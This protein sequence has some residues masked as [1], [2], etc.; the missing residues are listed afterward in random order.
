MLV[1][2]AGPGNLCLLSMHLVVRL[3]SSLSV[4]KFFFLPNNIFLIER[5]AHHIHDEHCTVLNETKRT[6][7]A[8][9]LA[10]ITE[11]NSLEEHIQLL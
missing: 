10:Y 11:H 4:C 2:P 7:G 8:C 5:L 1:S 9:G 6:S 3:H